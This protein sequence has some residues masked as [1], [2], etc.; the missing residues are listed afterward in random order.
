MKV[1]TKVQI[2]LTSAAE[3]ILVALEPCG[4]WIEQTLG[5]SMSEALILELDC[6][7]GDVVAEELL[8]GRAI[9]AAT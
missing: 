8:P 1:P 6:N 4:D 5:V 2:L 7:P 3:L 9:V